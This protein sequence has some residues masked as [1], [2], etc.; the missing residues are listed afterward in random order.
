MIRL[1]VNIGARD[2]ARPADLLGAFANE[3]GVESADVGRID[4]RD[5]HSIVEVAPAA[6]DSVIE[7]VTGTAIRGRRAI[8]R[9]DEERPRGSF[10]DRPARESRD[11]PPRDRGDRPARD[12]GDRPPRDRSDRRPVT[13]AIVRLATA[14]RDRHARSGRHAP[15]ARLAETVR[16]ASDLG[17]LCGRRERRLDR[18]HLRRDVQRKERG[19]HSPRA[20]RDHREEEGPGLQVTSRR[21][22]CRH[23]RDLEPRRPHRRGGPDRHTRADWPARGAGHAGRRDRRGAVPRRV[24]RR[25]RDV[26]RQS[27]NSGDHRRH[28]LRL[29]RRAVRADAAAAWRSPRSWTS[30][31]PSA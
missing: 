31:T 7:R 25:A 22:L 5:S 16:I 27:R 13:A 2:N 26:A 9:R 29:S 30:S 23:L 20:P 8:V 11:R 28:R 6:A 10:G 24:D 14:A 4:I 19:A 15:H 21:A 1:F 18:G 3:G 12:R 17:R